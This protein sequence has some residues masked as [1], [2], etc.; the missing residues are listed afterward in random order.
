MKILLIRR[1]AT[2]GNEI[3]QAI[4]L[5]GMNLCD[6]HR[7]E[8][9]HIAE[10][11]SKDTCNIYFFN[12]H[13]SQ[14]DRIFF[15]HSPNVALPLSAGSKSNTFEYCE[16]D[17]SVVSALQCYAGKVI[18][19]GLLNMSLSIK[20]R[21]FLVFLFKSL[22]WQLHTSLFNLTQVLPDKNEYRFYLLITTLGHRFYPANDVF[23]QVLDQTQ[24][25]IFRTQKAMWERGLDILQVTCI[26][27]N[28]TLY[29][30]GVSESFQQISAEVLATSLKEII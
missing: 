10:L 4:A 18:N 8:Q 27:E 15:M 2:A 3:K 9:I 14:F 16:L 1:D 28:G 23:R 22:G 25:L 20:N 17:A 19:A 13:I 6:V 21:Y 5:L 26:V 12:R 7:H 29:L 30:V 11:N 24:E